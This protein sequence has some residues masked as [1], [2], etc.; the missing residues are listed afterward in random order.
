[1]DNVK[2]N[3][4]IDKKLLTISFCYHY[5]KCILHGTNVFRFVYELLRQGYA[6][7]EK[8]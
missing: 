8:Q 5:T 1:M 2:K 3:S 6:A 7:N 4:K